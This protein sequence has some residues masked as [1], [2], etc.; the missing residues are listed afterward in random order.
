MVIGAL[1]DRATTPVMAAKIGRLLRLPE[2]LAYQAAV[3]VV[4]AQFGRQIG[5]VVVIGMRMSMI[6]RGAAPVRMSI[7]TVAPMLGLRGSDVRPLVVLKQQ[8]QPLPAGHER[9]E[10]GDQHT[11]GQAMGKCAHIDGGSLDDSQQATD[12]SLCIPISPLLRQKSS[13]RERFSQKYCICNPQP[14][15]FFD[16]PVFF[17]LSA[18]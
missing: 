3:M 18:Q 6:G 12:Q 15:Y 9:A 1:A 16:R 14:I 17:R 4:M 7:A 10:R 2:K 13:R 11:G 5:R 8:M